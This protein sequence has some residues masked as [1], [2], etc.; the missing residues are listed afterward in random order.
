ME[1]FYYPYKQINFTEWLREFALFLNRSIVNNVLEL[2]ASL[3]D[4]YM[5]VGYIEPGLSFLLA[6][7]KF[8]RDL[9]FDILSNNK[10]EYVL[11][12]TKLVI[13]GDWVFNVGDEKV[14]LQEETN[15]T[16]FMPGTMDHHKVEFKKGTHLK[17]LCVYLDQDWIETYIS[18]EDARQKISAY[19][20][21]G[22]RNFNKEILTAEYKKI[23]DALLEKDSSHPLEN[24]YTH[25]RVLHL[26][27]HFLN[28]IL[29]R[30]SFTIPLTIDNNDLQK[31]FLVEKYLLDNFNKQFPSVEEMAKIALMSKSKLKKI[32]KIAFGMGLYHYYQ[33]NRM[34]IAKELIQSQERTI[35]EIGYSLGY[36]NLSNFSI[37]FKKEYGV[38]PSEFK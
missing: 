34:R 25:T 17:V 21:M 18:N 2:P 5:K 4:G 16:V 24:L 36:S 20:E 26:L 35:S 15:E 14:V 28:S 22:L 7:F 9:V 37:A 8:N 23:F 10:P 13:S 19:S 32:F 33:K 30:I 27:E 1:T 11:Y 31:L 38:L 12:F 29:M 3:A 6:N